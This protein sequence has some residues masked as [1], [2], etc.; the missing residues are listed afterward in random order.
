MLGIF[1]L[2]PD[3]HWSKLLTYAR[4]PKTNTHNTLIFFSNTKPSSN[5]CPKELRDWFRLKKEDLV[6]DL[7]LDDVLELVQ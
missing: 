1:Y 7:G 3:L 4:L 6:A 5:Q 2:L